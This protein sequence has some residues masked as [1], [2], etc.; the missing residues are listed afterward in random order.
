[1]EEKSVGIKTLK[2]TK[3]LISYSQIIDVYENLYKTIIQHKKG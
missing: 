1:M 3:T 2:N